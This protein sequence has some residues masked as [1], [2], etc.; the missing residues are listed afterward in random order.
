MSVV[1]K[2]I[3]LPTAIYKTQSEISALFYGEIEQ[4]EK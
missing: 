2:F 3:T 4:K 1:T